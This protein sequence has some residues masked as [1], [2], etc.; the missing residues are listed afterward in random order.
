MV[1]V[2]WTIYPERD[3]NWIISAKQHRPPSHFVAL[4]SSPADIHYTELGRIERLSLG[5]REHRRT[6]IREPCLLMYLIVSSG[7]MGWWQAP[8]GHVT[9]RY[10]FHPPPEVFHRFI[11]PGDYVSDTL[12]HQNKSI[13]TFWKRAIALR[14]N[15]SQDAHVIHTVKEKIR[16]QYRVLFG[17]PFPLE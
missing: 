6:G 5:T 15:G 16:E 11:T 1:E 2:D 14:M 4:I 10:G 17:E 7:D 13:D 12:K 3:T 9:Y 8:Y